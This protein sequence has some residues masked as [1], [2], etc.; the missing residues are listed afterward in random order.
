MNHV[1]HIQR[2]CQQH[3]FPCDDVKISGVASR[4][5]LHG[6]CMQVCML[7]LTTCWE[8]AKPQTYENFDIY[9]HFRLR[10][11]V[12]SPSWGL[13]RPLVLLQWRPG[14]LLGS[15][16]PP[17]LELTRAAGARRGRP[18]TRNDICSKSLHQ[19][20]STSRPLPHPGRSL[21]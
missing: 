13:T 5:S 8:N 16:A 20:G 14:I 21:R 15:C 9:S 18:F 4:L 17:A 10:R 1:S 6:R 12:G 11:F 19:L 3:F 7:A 2:K